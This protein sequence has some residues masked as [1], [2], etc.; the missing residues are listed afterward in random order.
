MPGNPFNRVWWRPSVE[1]EV[2]DELAFH[3]EMRTRE[4]VES[5]MDPEAARREAERRLGGLRGARA[6]LNTLGEE[7]NLHMTRSQ[8]LGELGQD[9]AF[10]WRQLRRAPGFTAIAALTLALGIG[11]TTAIFSA[12]YAVVLQPI[13]IREPDRLLVV[14]ETFQGQL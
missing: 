2:D 10:T 8:Y 9:V 1:Q 5:G 7:R 14:G 13:S 11:G 6:A 12:V 4:L 3:L